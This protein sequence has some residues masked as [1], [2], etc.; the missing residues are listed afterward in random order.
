ME[1]FSLSLANNT[2]TFTLD[3]DEDD[4][5]MRKFIAHMRS[6]VSS[7][8]RLLHEVLKECQT[9]FT[10]FVKEDED[11]D[12]DDDDGGGNSGSGDEEEY[13]KWVDE[14]PVKKPKKQPSDYIDAKQFNFPSIAKGPAT[15]RL[16][17]DFAA[18]KV[19]V[20]LFLCLCTYH[21]L[22]TFV[23]RVPIPK[24]RL[25]SKRSREMGISTVGRCLFFLPRIL[26]CSETLNLSRITLTTP[27]IWKWFVFLCFPLSFCSA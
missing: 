6:F 22:L 24:K 10:K 5:G 23:S 27:S 21:I 9:S 11:D 14:E 3:E 15:Q 18:L 20:L 19:P 8:K 4:E 16:I 1:E 12:G 25:D 7:R 13:E 17:S 2:W 26:N